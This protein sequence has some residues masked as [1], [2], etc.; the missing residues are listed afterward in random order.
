MP[1]RKRAEPFVGEQLG[2]ETR[3]SIIPKGNTDLG[4]TEPTYDY[5]AAIPMPNQ[6]GVRQDSSLSSVIDAVKGMAFYMDTIGFAEPSSSLTQ[7]MPLYP[8]GINYF[9]PTYQ[10]C[11][12]G[13]RMWTYING[14]PKG[15]ALGSSV[16][17]AFK[18]SGFPALKGLAP[19]MV[20]DTKV[21]MNPKPFINAIIGDP[22]PDC[23]QKTLPIGTSTGVTTDLPGVQFELQGGRPVQTKWVQKTDGRG[24]PVF[25][26]REKYICTKKTHNEDGTIN[27][28]PPD[29]DSSCL[30]KENFQGYSEQATASL[31]VA[32]ALFGLAL[33]I[34]K[35][36]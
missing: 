15:D 4:Y 6:V 9:M 23:E 17:N 28:S 10:T 8:I 26:S 7:G 29:L 25:I 1:Q 31:A 11:P 30:R 32:A 22:F 12:N 36:N 5:S 19:G 27:P 21:A 2:N 24:K 33:Y 14:I 13:A 3:T 35:S 34:H 20:E 18:A 16:Q